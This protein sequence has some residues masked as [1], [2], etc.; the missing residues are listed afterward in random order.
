MPEIIPLT[1][2]FWDQNLGRLLRFVDLRE[3]PITRELS[4]LF[5]FSKRTELKAPPY[6]SRPP[7]P[8]DDDWSELI[9]GSFGK[10]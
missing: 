8:G 7:K 1:N 2:D 4:M 9:L 10:R 6:I 3:T 5:G